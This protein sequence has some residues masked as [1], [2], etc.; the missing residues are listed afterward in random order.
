MI[1]SFSKYL[2]PAPDRVHAPRLTWREHAHELELGFPSDLRRSLS[3]WENE[4]GALENS[5]A[6]S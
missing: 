3:R 2:L 1:M 4:G 5:S 6:G